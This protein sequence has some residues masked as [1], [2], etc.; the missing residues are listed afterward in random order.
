SASIGQC[1]AATLPGGRRVVVKVQHPDITAKVHSDLAILAE[2]ARLAEEYLSELRPYR[3]V[4]VVA[5]F[6][7]V[8]LREL[9]FRRE[10]RHL[11]LF[12]QA[13]A[14]DPLV[15]FPEPYP[16][17]STARVLTMEWV[18]GIPFTRPDKVKA[19]GGDFDDLARRGARV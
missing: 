19:A 14:K 6:H 18:D 1:H 5:E 4:A 7:R 2:L 13:F 15:R 3:P 17:F 16:A 9:D 8:L 11:Q 12:R 10:L